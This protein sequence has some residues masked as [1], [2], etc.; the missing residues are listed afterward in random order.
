MQAAKRD[1]S[2]LRSVWFLLELVPFW[3][4]FKGEPRGTPKS[5]LGCPP[6]SIFKCETGGS[7][8][9][10]RPGWLLQ[11]PLCKKWSTFSGFNSEHPTCVNQTIKVQSS[12]AKLPES[13]FPH[14]SRKNSPT[15]RKLYVSRIATFSFLRAL[16]VC[17]ARGVLWVLP[18]GCPLF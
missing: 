1:V 2:C 14:E 5:I 4:C 11:R 6:N 10:T 18:S 15:Y 17:Q 3:G 12:T 8:R 16:E 13:Q 9:E 7:E